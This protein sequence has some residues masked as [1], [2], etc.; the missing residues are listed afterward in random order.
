[1][2]TA[3]DDSLLQLWAK[4][5][6][7]NPPSHYPLVLHMIDVAAVAQAMW[8]KVLQ[9][10]TRAFFTEQLGVSEGDARRWVSFWA[11]LHDIGKATP[12]FQ[13]K[14]EY[15]KR[16]LK[17]LGFDFGINYDADHHG[18]AT[19]CILLDLLQSKFSLPKE[20]SRRIAFTLGGHHGIFPLS[21]ALVPIGRL[22][23]QRW[24]EQWDKL[25]D[26]LAECCEIDHAHLRDCLPQHGFFIMLAGFTAVADWVAS[27]EDWFPYTTLCSSIDDHEEIARHRAEKALCDLLWEYRV[28]MSLAGFAD[29]FD[30]HQTRPLQA[31]V[32]ELAAKLREKK[33]LVIIE[34]PMGEGKTEAAL[35][36]ADCWLVSQGQ[37]GCYFALPTQATSDQMF[38]RFKQFLEK[39]YQHDNVALMLLHGHASLNSEFSQLVRRF[40]ANIEVDSLP[41]YD[42][43][44]GTVAA[45]EWFTY[46]KRGLLAPFGIGT[47]DQ[48]LL[49]V[50][51]T[52]HHF[53]RLFG[54]AGKTVIFDEVHAYDAYM[55]TLLE[56]LVEWLAALGST[57]IILSATLP[58]A[59]R[60]ALLA[61]YHRGLSSLG[62][63]VTAPEPGVAYPRISW[64][65]DGK[66]SAETVATSSHSTKEIH[67]KWIGDSTL[68]SVDFELGKQLREALADGGCAAL[69]CNT[70]DHAQALYLKLK[71]Y[72]PA[73]AEDGEPE[74]ALL[75]ARYPFIERERREKHALLRFSRQNS[76]VDCGDEGIK[77]VFRPKRAVLVATQIIEQSLDLDFDLMV[78]EM[79]PVDLILQRAGRLHRHQ[80]QRPPAFANTPP[81]LWIIKPRL[82]DCGVPDFGSGTETV[83]DPHI[84][85]RSWLLLMEKCTIKIPEDVEPL[86]EM[87]YGGQ[88][89]GTNL[90]QAL[91]ERW[92]NTL[93]ELDKNR[94]RYEDM[95][96][97][98]SFPSPA[99]SGVILETFNTDLEEDNPEVHPTLQALTRLSEGPSISVLCLYGSTNTPQIG[100]GSEEILDVHTPPSETLVRKL[101]ERSLNISHK[102]AAISI[103]KECT[104]VPEQWRQNPLLRHHYM[105]F[106]DGDNICRLSDYTLRLDNE[107]GLTIEKHR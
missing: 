13:A 79:A 8:D 100:L 15:A 46:R 102:G 11:S 94:R 68:C 96:K 80:R 23:N 25:L 103:L 2:K 38:G 83:Y 17:S 84:L 81:Q 64:L 40:R 57:V 98:N 95:A 58:K 59:R 87:V 66:C 35:Y 89:W 92:Q 42:R 28:P 97:L 32:I 72:F 48:A 82:D 31:K 19:T 49:S 62:D 65:T 44:S 67:I 99:Y 43:T 45:S 70:V 10:S 3:M 27:N 107:L 9:A 37:K 51:Q 104:Q 75:H 18:I 78:T 53:V 52:R 74:L 12:T 29:C 56:R 85:L 41:S 60:K 76:T 7:G 86:I 21:S 24:R 101:L 71:K 105:L 36:L 14:S 4:K 90:P 33:G 93:T 5:S 91:R 47:I 55:V 26:M 88:D 73:K 1:M 22:G 20:L 106:F 54:L 61:A 50:L 63:T 77:Q 30:F 69:L 6:E 34:A 16:T 39:R